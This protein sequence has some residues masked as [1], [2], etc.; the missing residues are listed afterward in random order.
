MHNP[1]NSHFNKRD[2]SV[3]E[4]FEQLQQIY[5]NFNNKKR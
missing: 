3:T 1:N 2:E 5:F 4:D